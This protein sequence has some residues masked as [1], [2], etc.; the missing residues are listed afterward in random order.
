MNYIVSQILKQRRI[1]E[2]LT[3]KGVFPDGPETNGKL[4]YHCPIHANDNTPSFYVYL[5]S[6]EFENFYCFGCKAR[7]HIIHLYRDMEKVSLSEAV[8]ALADGIE[9]DINA[10][11]N[12]V[13]DDI[14]NDQS[15]MA[16][17]GPA[18]LALQINTNMRDFLSAV[19]MDQPCLASV[20]KV[21]QIVETAVE[22]GDIDTLDRIL[23]GTGPGKSLSDILAMKARLYFE[24]KEKREQEMLRAAYDAKVNQ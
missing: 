16:K 18:H 20:E 4:R 19:S 17:D 6:K 2:Y 3:K 5:R 21:G 1:T 14:N 12:H 15:A 7:Y 23:R 8:K 13:I 10:E 9:V 11:I 22:N 24:A